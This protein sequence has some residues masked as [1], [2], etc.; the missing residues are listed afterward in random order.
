LTASGC[1]KAIS[2]KWRKKMSEPKF[3]QGQ[4]VYIQKID[5]TKTV[6]SAYDYGDEWAYVL[7]DD[8]G[9]PDKGW[10]EDELALAGEPVEVPPPDS[11]AML[12]MHAR[13]AEILRRHYRGT[14]EA[15]A[16]EATVK[17]LDEITRTYEQLT[18]GEVQ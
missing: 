13:I 11:N 9:N 4:K 6:V 2:R 12:G 7:Q 15:M 16:Q 5:T 3:T 18:V 10:R 1:A 14:G 8:E 17:V